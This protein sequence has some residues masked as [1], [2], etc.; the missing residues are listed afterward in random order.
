M[1]NW[2]MSGQEISFIISHLKKDDV[3]FEYGSG[4]STILFPRL[5]KKYISIEHSKNWYDWTKSYL[6]KNAELIFHEVK[7]KELTGWLREIDG[8]YEEFKDYVEAIGELKPDVILID[9]R[10]RLA[11]AE[12]VKNIDAKIFIHDY[13]RYEKD[14]KDYILIKKVGSMALI[15]RSRNA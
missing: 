1:R 12:R 6:P 8:T 3:F 9:G 7:C 13:H 11:C 15:K 14:I 5:V 10:A 4:Y 2:Q